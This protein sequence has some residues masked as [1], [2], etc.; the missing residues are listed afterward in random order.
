MRGANGVRGHGEGLA[1]QQAAEG[2][3][4][5]LRGA[6]E[7]RV[8]LG[9]R[10]LIGDVRFR[11]LPLHLLV[12]L[13]PRRGGIGSGAVRRAIGRRH[14]RRARRRGS[15]PAA[16]GT[17]GFGGGS[18][19]APGRRIGLAVVGAADRHRERRLP[20]APRVRRRRENSSSSAAR[21]T[22]RRPRPGARG[23]S[24]APVTP[25]WPLPI[26]ATA[27]VRAGRRGFAD[28]ARQHRP[29]ADLD[30]RAHARRVHRLDL[31]DEADRARDLRGQRARGPRRDRRGYGAASAFE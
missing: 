15:S 14:L 22:E 13:R 16:R 5:R 31:L 8:A 27:Q 11:G 9:H 29:R 28:Q 24:R 7:R 25:C 18:A 26:E 2:G 23:R 4:R 12:R 19:R 10:T 30:E 21:S 20:A 3:E 1:A 17:G 6:Q